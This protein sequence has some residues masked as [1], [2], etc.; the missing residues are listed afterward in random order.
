M[1]QEPRWLIGG[2]NPSEERIPTQQA[3]PKETLGEFVDRVSAELPEDQRRLLDHDKPKASKVKVKGTYRGRT[4]DQWREMAKRSGRKEQESIDRSDTDGALSQMG[5]NL[6]AR[7]Y[8]LC[9][10]L[11][12]K[13]GIWEFPALFTLTGALVPDAVYIKIKSTGKWVWRIGRGEGAQWFNESQAKDGYRRRRNDQ[14]KG[15]YVGLV[16]AR[17]YVGTSGNGRG[18][19]GM[20]SVGYFIGRVEQSPV[21]TVDNGIGDMNLATQYQDRS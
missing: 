20:L 3:A 2:P 15:F 21:E 17:G 10:Q 11:A 16:R 4:A 12:E 14:A 8:L 9:A 19:A 1:T 13:D 7:E 18:S 6:N 5:H